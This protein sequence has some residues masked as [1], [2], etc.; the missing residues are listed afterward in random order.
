MRGFNMLLPL[1]ANTQLAH[2]FLLLPISGFIMT[3]RMAGMIFR[4]CR[5]VLRCFMTSHP[6]PFTVARTPLNQWCALILPF[7]SVVTLKTQINPDLASEIRPLLVLNHPW[8][9]SVGLQGEEVFHVLIPHCSMGAS[10]CVSGQLCPSVPSH[11]DDT[12]TT[13]PPKSKL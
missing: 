13:N 9:I 11:A 12:A 5:F 6:L 7:L 8:Q 3:S 10:Y 4:F 2:S 1:F